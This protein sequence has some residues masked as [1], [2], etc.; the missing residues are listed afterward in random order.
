M[1]GATARRSDGQASVR[2]P[3][4]RRARGAGDPRGPRSARLVDAVAAHVG[5]LVGRLRAAS[6]G[7]GPRRRIARGRSRG[8]AALGREACGRCSATAAQPDFRRVGDR[9]QVLQVVS[10]PAKARAGG[11][12][13][14]RACPGGDARAGAAQHRR[15]GPRSASPPRTAPPAPAAAVGE[16]HAAVSDRARAGGGHRR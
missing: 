8:Q 1:G 13:R 2:V 3:A 12:R 7:P 4:R 9:K 14:T 15:G 11:A 16:T 10:R 6:P 5:L